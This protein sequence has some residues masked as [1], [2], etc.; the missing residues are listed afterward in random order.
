MYLYLS[1][2]LNYLFKK[3]E[4]NPNKLSNEIDVAQ[5]TLFRIQSN[6]SKQPNRSAIEKIAEWAKVTPTELTD[7]DLE[8][9]AKSASTNDES[10]KIWVSSLKFKSSENHKNIVKIPVYKDVKASCGNGVVNFLEEV[11]D[12]FE[13]DP[14]ILRILGIQA[15]PENLKIIYSDEYSMWPTV[16]PDSPLFVD[17][18]PID[19]GALKNGN[20]Y[21]FCH[22]NELR[23]KRIFLSVLGDK[24]VRLS[25]DNPDKAKYPDEYISNEQ[26]N[27]INFVGRLESALVKP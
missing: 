23:M 15:K 7:V 27:E 9:R 19:L 21:V 20:V 12:Y 16:A 14:N 22:N 8:E 13:I 5:S 18:T 25:S 26:L 1:K 4:T 11:S 17:V 10:S 3:H 6:I 24:S 2:N